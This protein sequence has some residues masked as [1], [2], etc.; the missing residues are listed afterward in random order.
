MIT[1]KFNYEEKNILDREKLTKYKGRDILC[2][3][4][5]FICIIHF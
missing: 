5:I 4:I 2:N 1:E 3:E